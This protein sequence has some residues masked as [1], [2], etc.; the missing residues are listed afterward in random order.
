MK[1]KAIVA[2]LLLFAVGFGAFAEVGTYIKG[3]V[4]YG[5]RWPTDWTTTVDGTDYDWSSEDIYGE[6]F[7]G[8]YSHLAE[9]VPTFG[10]EPWRGSG[11]A[12]LRGLSFE[13]SVDVGI[14][15][16][17]MSLEYDDDDDSGIG[18][19]VDFG[20]SFVISPKVMAVYTHR[21]GIVAPYLGLGVSVPIVIIPELGG[22]DYNYEG[23]IE[24]SAVKVGV[25]GNV[26]AGIGF[27]V[28]PSIMPVFEVDFAFGTNM[29]I[30]GR[31]GI[32]Y[33]FGM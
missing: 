33:R 20:A 26:M 28:T 15:N 7:T 9:I 14:G 23:F 30:D 22:D 11:S 19:I 27:M 5:Y 16:A 3:A 31:A 18:Y 24:T 32:V 8:F 25:N 29:K 1:K 10:I 21:A 4:G 12:F 2:S 17:L 6:E 13:I